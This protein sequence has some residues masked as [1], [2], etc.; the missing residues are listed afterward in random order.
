MTDDARLD[1]RVRGVLTDLPVPDD[2]ETRDALQAVLA[3][4]RGPRRQVGGWVAPAIVAAAIVLVALAVGTWLDRTNPVEPAPSPDPASALV[5]E[6]QRQVTGAATDGWD[7]AW[8]LTLRQ[9]GVLELRG[10]TTAGASS[11]GASWTATEGELRTDV[12]VNSVCAEQPAGVYTW[13]V[14]GDGLRLTL[15]T[16]DCTARADVF[17]GTWRRVG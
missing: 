7:G 5:G 2:A 4:S 3:R 14:E 17:A 6:W 12:F 11:E 16:T 10:P 8:R 1:A 15:E 13:R 9:D